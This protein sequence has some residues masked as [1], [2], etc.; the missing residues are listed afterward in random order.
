MSEAIITLV[1][2]LSADDC[3]EIA[4]WLAEADIDS[5][6]FG[7]PGQTLR[8][9]RADGSYQM[10][11]VTAQER[12]TLNATCSDTHEQVTKVRAPC[13]GVV[14]DRHPQASAALAQIGQVVHAGELIG[15]L[16]I[17]LVLAP[18]IAPVT[19]IVRRVV[20]AAGTTVGFGAELFELLQ[21][22][23]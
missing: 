18:V 3:Q 14:L 16:Q 10:Q 11:E 12:T 22:D 5:I 8:M 23:S 21:G 13:A 19:G 1:Q 15:L 7:T 4:A 9:T 20:W 17:G 2:G 6:E